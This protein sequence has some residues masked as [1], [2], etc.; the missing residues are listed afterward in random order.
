MSTIQLLLTYKKV[1][2]SFVSLMMLY[3]CASG[4]SRLTDELL[5]AETGLMLMQVVRND[6]VEGPKI[7]AIEVWSFKEK[8]VYEIRPS[9]VGAMSTSVF[10][11]KLPP[12]KYRVDALLSVTTGVNVVLTKT[13]PL[14]ELLD[15]FNVKSGQLTD[16]GTLVYTPANR[17]WVNNNFNIKRTDTK[18]ESK[19]IM[20]Y[21]YP[22]ISNQVYK[23]PVLSWDSKVPK[24]ER[25]DV[26][27]NKKNPARFN[28]PK[29]TNKGEVIAGSRL[30]QVLVRSRNGQWKVHDTG[31]LWEI[32][33]VLALKDGRLLAASDHGLLLLSD[34]RRKKWKVLNTPSKAPIMSIAFDNNGALLA[35]TRIESTYSFDIKL[36]K[37]RSITKP[38]WVEY[39]DSVQLLWKNNESLLAKN[40]IMISDI[41]A[42]IFVHD[43][44]KWDRNGIVSFGFTTE[45]WFG[46]MHELDGGIFYYAAKSN[47]QYGKNEL[48][49]TFRWSKDNGVTWG[50]IKVWPETEGLIDVFFINKKT[51]YALLANKDR[52]YSA[53]TNDGG[54]NWVNKGS[55]KIKPSGLIAVNNGKTI[56]AYNDLGTVYGSRNGGKS[57]K[58]ER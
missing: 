26:V 5:P 22:V 38:K 37:T 12:G 35:V 44:K 34:K 29:V 33:D 45:E 43:G 39:P 40:G 54:I 57:W 48:G 11:H 36:Y 13:I 15:T 23:K 56:L 14:N 51:G 46:R 24:N 1:L 28:N 52:Y 31:Y 58:L 49:H 25:L 3:G 27:K 19:R 6:N 18:K 2:I 32:Y 41:P 47:L 50:N 8:R 55:I 42:A 4:P 7:N 53:S 30:G 10:M 17:E 20:K 9:Q 16:L 21:H